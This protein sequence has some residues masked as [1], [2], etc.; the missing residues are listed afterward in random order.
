MDI[1]ILEGKIEEYLPKRKPDGNKS[2]FGKLLVVAGS[3][4]MSGA[5]YLS[6]YAALRSGAGLVKVYTHREALPVIRINLPEALLCKDDKNSLLQAIEWCNAIVLGPGLGMNNRAKE[7]CITVLKNASVPLIIDADAINLLGAD[8][9]VRT[10]YFSYLKRNKGIVPVLTPHPKEAGGLLELSTSSLLENFEENI[11]RLAK[12]YNA[13]V[14]GKNAKSIIASFDSEL[15][16][17]NIKGNDGMA[18]AGSGD[19]LAGITGGLLVQ[20]MSSID[21]AKTACYLHALAGDWAAQRRNR[22][23]LIARDIIEGI[24]EV[25]NTDGN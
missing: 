21:A 24:G 6:A 23:S 11:I 18:T 10:E 20:N 5:P 15:A 7:I 2:S 13:V 12:E 19:V 14:I 9:D 17:K 8:K 1:E 4:Y 3:K 25:I 22:Y 16:Y